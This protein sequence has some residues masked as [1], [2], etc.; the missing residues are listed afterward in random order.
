MNIK[1][2]PTLPTSFPTAAE[3]DQLISE[4]I[5]LRILR[6]DV[7]LQVR[8]TL[9]QRVE[10][11][12]YVVQNGEQLYISFAHVEDSQQRNYFYRLIQRY[13][14]GEQV[15]LKMLPPVLQEMLQPELTRYGRV[16]GAMMMG[17]V[18][19]IAIGILAMAAAIL[20]TNTV[21]WIT[22]HTITQYMGMEVTAVAFIVCSIVGWAIFGIL[23]WNK[24]YLWGDFSKSAATIRR[25]L[26]R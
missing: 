12:Q 8:H 19:G 22:G 20:V 11:R 26:F 9:E 2:K 13:Q 3:I 14:S 10:S 7:Q 5:L 1:E 21:E 6:P 17:A 24:P 16:I 4:G 18:A 23:A 15:N 25:K